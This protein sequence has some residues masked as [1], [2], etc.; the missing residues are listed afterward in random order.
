MSSKIKRLKRKK[1]LIK[2]SRDR[3]KFERIFRKFRCRDRSPVYNGSTI[4]VPILRDM[5][6]V[7]DVTVSGFYIFYLN[8]KSFLYNSYLMYSKS[9]RYKKMIKSLK[10]IFNEIDY[11]EKTRICEVGW[12][13]ELGLNIIHLNNRQRAT[14]YVKV[15][16]FAKKILKS[17]YQQ[18]KP[19]KNDMLVSN[20]EG[21]KNLQRLNKRGKLNERIGFGEIKESKKQYAKYDENLNLIPV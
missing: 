4:Y 2:A 16:K 13:V 11:K 18:Y 12:R 6:L 7:N 15:L 3:C 9:M 10:L 14:I 21:P 17:G 8:K 1:Y 19:R 5:Q 20:P